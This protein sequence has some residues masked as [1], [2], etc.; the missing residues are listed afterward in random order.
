MGVADPGLG[1]SKTRGIA[2]WS[3]GLGHKLAET[4][5]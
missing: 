1:F 5:K 3:D 2:K 4:G